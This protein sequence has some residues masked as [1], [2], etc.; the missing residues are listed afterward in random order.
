MS[1]FNTGG[2]RV[3]GPNPEHAAT[4]FATV[5]HASFGKGS[6]MTPKD[7]PLEEHPGA[8]PSTTAHQHRQLPPRTDIDMFYQRAC[9]AWE[10]RNAKHTSC[11]KIFETTKA[12]PADHLCMVKCLL[13]EAQRFQSK[14]GVKLLFPTTIATLP[15]AVAERAGA[16]K[17]PNFTSACNVLLFKH[18]PLV[19]QPFFLGAAAQTNAKPPAHVF[20]LVAGDYTSCLVEIRSWKLFRQK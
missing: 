3:H 6:R 12:S 2:L 13:N 8:Q 15:P 17:D 14:K 18:F 5:S 9:A 19:K 20:V 16:R 10:S 1:R 11:V 7:P 4:T